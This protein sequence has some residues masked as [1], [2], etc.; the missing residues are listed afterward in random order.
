L[1][2]KKPADSLIE[3]FDYSVQEKGVNLSTGQRQRLALARGLLACRD[4]LGVDQP[5]TKFRRAIVVVSDGDDNQ[6]DY[7]RDQ[8]LEMAQKAD[9]V[10]YAISTNMSHAETEGDRVLKYYTEQTGGRAFFPFKVEDLEQSFENIA[11][12]LRHQY[13]ILYRPEPLK[14][15]GLWHPVTL[16]VKGRKDLVVRARAGY[17]APKL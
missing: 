9:V 2:A 15:D 16:R 11:N 12:E 17:Y 6:S 10:I 7:T 8:A 4:K 13:N 5:R 1:P 3:K 14:T